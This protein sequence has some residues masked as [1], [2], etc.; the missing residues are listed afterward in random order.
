MHYFLLLVK[1]LII[2][3]QCYHDILKMPI[4]INSIAILNIHSVD[5]PC[6]IIRIS[7]IKA[8]NSL[9]NADLSENSGS[10]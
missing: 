7:K 2:W 10:L 3:L 9:K 1:K 6:I 5:Y 8:I 4:D